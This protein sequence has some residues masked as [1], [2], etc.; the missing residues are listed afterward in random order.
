MNMTDCTTDGLA[1]IGIEGDLDR[2]NVAEFQDCISAHLTSGRRRVVVDLQE[3]AFID[4][5]GLGALLYL[6][7]DI[8]AEGRLAVAGPSRRIKR[9]FEIVG[10]ERDQRFEIHEDVP[11][12]A[13]AIS[14]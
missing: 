2:S 1:V 6:V 11:A 4:S 5:A 8:G 13:A 14:S 12:A 3:C 7:V 10:L 9:L